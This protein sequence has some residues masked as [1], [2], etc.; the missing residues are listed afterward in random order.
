[1]NIIQTLKSY[2]N[3]KSQNAQ[4]YA[5]RMKK[6]KNIIEI[7]VSSTVSF[8]NKPNTNIFTELVL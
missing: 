8:K 6:Q 2:N 4:P 5:I 3:Q 7:Y 1:M